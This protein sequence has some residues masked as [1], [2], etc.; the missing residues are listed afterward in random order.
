[1]KTCLLCFLAIA[2][3]A[4]AAVRPLSL[5]PMPRTVIL[6]EGALRIDGGFSVSFPAPPAARLERGVVRMI[7]EL[8]NRTG[9]PMRPIVEKAAR[10]ASLFIECGERSDEPDRL[11][12]DESYTL[13][14][15]PAQARLRAATVVGALHG[16]QTFLQL[17]A[18]GRSGFEAQAVHI[19]DRP[20]FPWRG[21]LL[22]VTSHW[23]PAP[24]IER[25]LDAMEA[26][27]LNV[28]HWHLT[29]D[30]GFRIESEA[31]PKLHQLGSDGDYY[32]RA[33]IRHILEYAHDR[34]IR[35]V[36]EIDMPGHCASWL[37]GYPELASIPGKYSIIH[38]FGVYDPAIDPTRDLV[39]E[40]L[41]KLIGEVA[42]LFPDVYFHIG[43]D[44]V[45]GKQW[46]ASAKI[47]RFIREHH[48]HDEAGL[49]AYFNRRVEALVKKHGK[50]MM[51]WDEILHPGLPHDVILQSWR[52]QESLVTAVKR[53]HR[54]LLSYGYYLDHL[55]SA[56]KHYAVD[57]LGGP[58]K[59]LT[60]EEAARVL[61][62]EAC[63]WTEYVDAATVDSR[64][65]PRGAAI[66]ERL[67][68][69]A[70]QTDV[71]SLYARL[72][73]VSRELDWRGVRHEVNYMPMLQ[74][75]AP[76][77]EELL[78][79]LAG[80]V[81]PLG[82]DGREGNH[83]Y[84]QS[85]PLN[86][87]V[88]AARPESATVRTMQYRIEDLTPQNE[89]EIRG[90]L[91]RWKSNDSRLR[92]VLEANFLLREAIPL[93][94]NLALAGAIG[95]DALDRIAAHR[96]PPAG[97]AE[98]QLAILKQMDAPQAEVVLAAVRPV[99]ALVRKAGD[100]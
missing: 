88:D 68:S 32:T 5:L 89:R 3:S 25:N 43:G 1:M 62:G 18:P 50:I 100:L 4:A 98:K 10:G 2:A 53:G 49:Q 67:W 51:G 80:V 39:Y 73:A 45:N 26:V 74:R 14:V 95:L 36:P 72:D 82:I 13:D 35:V 19:E 63:M 97:W 44:E 41:D 93:S 30:Q 84:N 59:G 37:V 34:G 91:L 20:R 85:T 31:F 24:V 61:G 56:A 81:E 76:G 16:L 86:R 33:D 65:W 58:A 42:A 92:P 69:T 90:I 48:L 6:H 47:Q 28:F 23:M 54:G 29:D 52:D 15:T 75:L 96:P 57:P 70:S 99:R 66:A 21:F 38:T 7:R 11:G 9:V 12:Q 64:N 87:L 78:G 83:R 40:F 8:S 17:A 55:D 46:K 22:D 79:T 60:A 27:K 71:K 77:H 94:H